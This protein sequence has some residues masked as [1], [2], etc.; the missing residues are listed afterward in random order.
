MVIATGENTYYGEV[1]AHI[2]EIQHTSTVER[3]VLDVGN[4]LIR[5]AII[6]IIILSTFLAFEH[7]EIHDILLFALTLAVA[8]IPAALPAVLTVVS[9]MGVLQL[10]RKSVLVRRLSSLEDLASIQIFL[11]DKTGTLTENKIRVARIVA[12]NATEEEVLEYAHMSSLDEEDPIDK[13]IIDKA[14]ELE[15]GKPKFKIINYIPPDSERKRSTL[16]IKFNNKIL[17][18]VKGSPRVLLELSNAL[19]LKKKNF[20][21]SLKILQNL[22]I[23]QLLLV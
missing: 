21:I 9:S 12:I 16:T 13:A 1:I 22:V 8:S 19:K 23:G 11:S 6:L 2:G 20:Q 17:T 10:S 3:F 5:I 14:L 7:H 4:F 15:I 18:L